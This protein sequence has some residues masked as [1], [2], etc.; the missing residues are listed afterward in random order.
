MVAAQFGV[1][2][3][4]GL[5]EARA[6]SKPRDH[7]GALVAAAV[8]QALLLIAVYFFAQDLNFPR[9]IFVV[10]AGLNAALLIAWRLGTRSLARSEPRRRVVVV[11]SNASAAEVIRTIRVQH[12]L[13]MDIVGAVAGDG[14]EPAFGDVPVLGRREDLPAVCERHDVDEVI[15]ASDLDWQD[16]LLDA[17]S[18]WKGRARI[19]VVPSPYEILISRTEHLRLHDIPL[20]EVIRAPESGGASVAKRVFDVVLAAALALALVPVMLLVALAIKL[21]SRGP[22]LYRQERVG[23]DGKVFTM[24]KFRTMREGAERLTGPVLAAANDPRVTRLGR[25]LRATRLDE[26]PQLANVLCGEM[27]FVGPRPERPEFARSFERE[28]NGYAE[29]FTVRPGLTGYAQVNGE[30]HTSAATKLKYDLAYIHNR[31]L[32]LD[33]KILSETFKVMLTRRGI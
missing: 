4:L 5:Y 15:I 25:L 16:R 12:W 29:R 13:G 24:L 28:I 2:Y 11:G 31:S 20:V 19:S 7:V 21:S 10:L 22:V 9:S 30:Y 17:L 26:L 23:K 14:G 6:V 1:L 32:W 27:S 18:R 33:L 3:F 8:L